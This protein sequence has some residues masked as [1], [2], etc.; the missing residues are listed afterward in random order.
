ERS[1]TV[2]DHR[3]VTLC[4]HEQARTSTVVVVGVI[5]CPICAA[6]LCCKERPSGRWSQLAGLRKQNRLV[7]RLR[8]QA[9]GYLRRSEARSVDYRAASSAERRL[10]GHRLGL[11][12][13]V[14]PPDKPRSEGL[15]ARAPEPAPAG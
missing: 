14:W 8:H 11:A 10:N 9:A 3:I 13:P 7:T 1:P 12:G 4:R 15:S 5:F 2:A 6:A